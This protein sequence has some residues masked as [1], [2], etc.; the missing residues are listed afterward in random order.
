MYK[1]KIAVRKIVEF[2]LRRGDIDSRKVSNHTAQEGAR[3]HRRLQKEAGDAYQK[4]VFFK[5]ESEIE[6]DKLT[7]EGR[8]DGLFYDEEK[9]C[10]VIDEIK[11]SEPYFEDLPED[12]IDLFFAQGM[13]YA[14]IYLQEEKLTEIEV[15]LTYYQTT[16]QL[17]TRVRRHFT[18]EELTEFYTHLINEYHKWLVFQENWR[19]VRNTSLQ[20]LKFPFE[21]YRKGQRELAAAAY[22]TLKNGKRLFAEAPTGTGKTISTLFPAL[23]V[24]G[25]GDGDR[26]FY[27][28]AKTITRQVAED[29]LSK[30]ADNG[31]ETKSVT[32]TA[33]DKICFLDERNCTPEHCPYANGYYNRINEALWDLLHHENQ[34]TREVIETY[35]KKHTVCPFELSLD[36]SVFC[37]VIIG[38]Y[39]Y[40][41]D[42]TVYLRRFFEEPEED[43]FFLIDEAH[44]LVNRSKEMY[45]AEIRRSTF[46][47][48]RKQLPMDQQKLR[49][50]LNKV[51]KEFSAIEKIAETD[52]WE[53]HHQKEPHE[54]MNK[55]LAKLAELMK[56]W[57]P[58]NP[59]HTAQE[60]VLQSYFEVNHFLKIAEFYDDHYETTVEVTRY[61]LTLRQFCIEPAPFLQQVL[62][63]GKAS[64]LFSASFTPLDY[65]QEVLGGGE[66]ALRYRLPSPFD[67][68]NQK[69]LIANYIQT[70]YRQ[71][72]ASLP[73]I[74]D[75]LYR[76]VH[77]KS[78]NYMVFFPSY[79]YLDEV[80]E[81]FHHAYPTIKMIVQDTAMNETERE[82]FLAEFKYDTADAEEKTSLIG[83]CVLGGI[84]SE[85]IDLKGTRLI[86]TAIVGVGLPQ[87]NHEQELIRDYYEEKKHAG[88]AYAYR[89]PGMNKVLQAAGR[90]I[91]D[92]TDQ[93]VI[94]LLDQRFHTTAYQQLF[95]LHWQ[96][97]QTCFRPEQ[98][99]KAMDHF[100]QKQK[101]SQHRS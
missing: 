3:I 96:H 1:G 36:V 93:G 98:L 57:L 80:A 85:G 95:P 88:F 75:A 79:Q 24:L 7:I 84:F 58:A 38:D 39:N 22:K 71:R 34:I 29:A 35:G 17:I 72:T 70:T 92:S 20:L 76:M 16:E 8:A 33:K 91:R 10:W 49:R 25:E 11:T 6:K 99:S 61:E 45:S 19:R 90:V 12:Q 31:S 37:D 23:K 100:W 32:L 54:T 13:V 51:E 44:N 2:I 60:A 48:L 66:K 62:D 65:Y 68:A 81:A 42:P 64:L 73:A 4:E 63:K 55:Q 14:Y 86:G 94:L 67:P 69:I 15:Q 28:T 52:H 97:A 5:I 56:E 9:Q 27:L 101:D 59:E 89:L 47:D 21:T 78:G 18:V 26:L 53:Y 46:K 83:F 82:N 87:I 50:A 77:A 41:F 30:L 74:V 43:Y 40:L